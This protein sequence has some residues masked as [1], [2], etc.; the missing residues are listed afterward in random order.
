MEN[1]KIY[2]LL[3]IGTGP[4][5]YT[6]SLYASRYALDNLIV[7][8][9]PGGLI[10]SA[11]KIC[12]YPSEYE[13]S[14]YELSMKMKTVVEKNG[15]IVVIDKVIDIQ[16]DIDLGDN[17]KG[18][19]IV[20]EANKEFLGKNLLISSGTKHRSLGLEAEKKLTGKG[21]SY[22]ATCDAMFYKNKTVVV[23]G[24]G[25]SANTAALYLAK[26]ATK[27]YQVYRKDV[28]KGEVA[29]VNQI[30]KN[31][32]IEV[33]YNTN[34]IDILGEDKVNKVI[35][36]N[37]YNGSKELDV[38]GVFIEIG[39]LPD[40]TMFQKLGGDVDERGYMIVNKDQSTN[41]KGIWGAGDITNGSNN[42]RQIVT[43]CS[44][45]AIAAES[46]YKFKV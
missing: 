9:Q 3:I 19:K 5:G 36:D 8:A 7:G 20:T 29:W 13:I 43:A 38:D 27:V 30:L 23:I 15:A 22:C 33:V 17:I 40:T 32:K 35:L 21:I 11:H 4:A 26:I 24:G 37:E 45:G 12:N 6:A 39:S 41:I 46:I 18:F 2:D 14:G 16:K 1:N 10:V 25:D 28:L 34:V 31:D 42:F 44:E